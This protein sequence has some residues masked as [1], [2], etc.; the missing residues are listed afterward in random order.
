[1]PEPESEAAK[2]KKIIQNNI[3]NKEMVRGME[4]VLEINKE[5]SKIGG[6]DVNF[7]D[8][9]IKKWNQPNFRPDR[10]GDVKEKLVSAD[11]HLQAKLKR[12]NNIIQKKKGHYEISSDEGSF[13]QPS[14]PTEE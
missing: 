12:Q 9:V 2:R 5:Q 8:R 6:V 4:A 7:I 11:E 1:M 14:P 10:M 13:A 3:K